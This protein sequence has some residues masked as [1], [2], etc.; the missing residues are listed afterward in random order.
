[1][2]DAQKHVADCSHQIRRIESFPPVKGSPIVCNDATVS[3]FLIYNCPDT[4][5]TDLTDYQWRVLHSLSPERKGRGRPPKY[6]RR[7]IINAILYLK[8]TGCQWRMLLRDF[9]KW[10]TVDIT[11]GLPKYI[12]LTLGWIPQPVL[13]PVRTSGL[14]VLPKHW[15]VERTSAWISRARRNAKDHEKKRGIGRGDGSHYNDSSYA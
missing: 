12:K 9:P 15:I 11:C 14:I 4:Y 5:P 3:I 13:R 8:Q 10:M 1:M 2:P 6:S 7:D